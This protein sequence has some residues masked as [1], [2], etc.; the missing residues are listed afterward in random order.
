[1]RAFA[2]LVAL[3]GTAHAGRSFAGWLVGT[4]VL[5]EHTV[6]FE[7]WVAERND[8]GATHLRETS[9]TWA[10]A[11]SIVERL[12]LVVPIEATDSTELGA[13]PEFALRRL[14]TE[15]RY[16]LGKPDPAPPLAGLLR[17]RLEQ[18]VRRHNLLRATAGAGASYERDRVQVAGEAAI[19][20]EGGLGGVHREL[21]PGL[22]VSVR[23]TSELRLGGELYA[24]ISHDA[25]ATTWAA[26]GPTFAW[27]HG[28]L[29]FAGNY[30]FGI[31]R[32]ASA[33]RIVFGTAF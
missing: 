19:V 4:E 17:F 22:G 25:S 29:W 33:A 28:R 27:T 21:R 20:F 10:L 1:M 14:G 5:P 13:R 11:A 16:R 31:D 23:T 9:I 2:I 32:I 26:I 30:G 18:D 7:T 24:E 15:L 12:E 3:A 6:E 8:V